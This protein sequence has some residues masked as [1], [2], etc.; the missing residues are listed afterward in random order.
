MNRKREALREPYR[1]AGM[2]CTPAPRGFLWALGAWGLA[3]AVIAL[4]GITAWVCRKC[5]GKV[6]E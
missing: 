3:V 5:G 4:P 1:V 2:E 6:E